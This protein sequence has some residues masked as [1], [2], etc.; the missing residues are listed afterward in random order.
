MTR[1]LISSGS[2]FERKIG[3]SRAVVQTT[4]IGVWC[5]VAGTTG[6]DYASMTMP[7]DPAAQ[8]R[9]AVETIGSALEDA[10]LALEDVY[11][12]R[13][14][15]TDIA[16]YGAVVGVLGARFGD[17][18]PASTFLVAGLAAPEMKVEIEADAFRAA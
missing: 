10:G 14:Y 8:T 17:I 12:T 2:P 16:F 13:I 3:Y 9:N 18:R 11:R 4:P 6:Y 1:R 5:F 7:D 15:V